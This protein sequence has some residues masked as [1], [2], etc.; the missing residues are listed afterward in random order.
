MDFTPLIPIVAIIAFAA[1]R[2]ARLRAT[3]PETPSADVTARLEALERTVQGLQQELGDTQE[4]LDFTER[5]LS[6]A[7]DERRLGS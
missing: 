6:K 7:R 3:R 4:R 5:L 1:V 2:I